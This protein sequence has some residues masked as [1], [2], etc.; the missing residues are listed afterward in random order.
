[1]AVKKEGLKSQTE[2]GPNL[3]LAKYQ[4]LLAVRPWAI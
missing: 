4:T 3:T 2:L 1:M